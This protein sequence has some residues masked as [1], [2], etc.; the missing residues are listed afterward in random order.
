MESDRAPSSPLVRQALLAAALMMAWN[1]TAKTTRDSLFLSAFPATSLPAMMGGA[2]VSSIL[3]AVLNVALLRR[4]GPSRIVR[5]GFLT[6]MALHAA[7]W[8]LLPR[9]PHLVAIAVYIHV[10]ALG[11]VLL[12]GFWALANEQF[13]PREARRSF[14]R[15]AA[16]GTVGTVVG[17]LMTERV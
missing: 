11:S 14:G 2:A 4:F 3:M 13:N 8:A 15:M 6:G 16:F 9:A 7:E 17:G 10:V 1:V 12:S 5:Y